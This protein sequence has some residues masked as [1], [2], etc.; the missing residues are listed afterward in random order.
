MA[1]YGTIQITPP[2]AEPLT[3]AEAARQTGASSDLHTQHFAASIIAA[4]QFIESRLNRQLI[5]ATWELR[6]DRFPRYYEPIRLPKA[7]LQ[8]AT[9]TYTDVDG[10]TQTLPTS[11]YKV[12]TSREPGEIR[13]KFDQFWPLT[14]PEAD[15]VAVQFVAGY[16]LAAVVP[17]GI[18]QAM[19]LLVDH[20][21]ENRSALLV[22]S[23]S[24]DLEF[25][26]TSLLEAY[27]YGDEFTCYAD[28]VYA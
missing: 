22:G 23:I 9:I 5:T 3:I 24:K 2:A 1:R 6:L 18:K 19:L 20:W 14:Y 16:G 12:V 7:P 4:R 25:S 13:L 27:N 26:L 21:F 28:Q 8:S 10:A 17:H 15:V 11:V